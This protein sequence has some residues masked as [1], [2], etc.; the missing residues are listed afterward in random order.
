MVRK[1]LIVLIIKRRRFACVLPKFLMWLTQSVII[2][3]Q[4]NWLIFHLKLGHN[5]YNASLMWVLHIVGTCG[6]PSEALCKMGC[7]TCVTISVC[8]CYHGPSRLSPIRL[9][10]NQ[11]LCFQ[12]GVSQVLLQSLLQHPC[13]LQ[14]Q[15]FKISHS[16]LLQHHHIMLFNFKLSLFS[17]WANLL[18]YKC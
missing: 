18:L 10:W 13:S 6:L 14:A 16:Y 12:L 4:C 15:Q 9:P 8:T 11:W 5:S 17:E 3:P 7:H 1:D 2:I